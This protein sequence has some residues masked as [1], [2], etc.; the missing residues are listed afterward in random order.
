[1]KS[2]LARMEALRKGGAARLNALLER[3]ATTPV[4]ATAETPLP[5]SVPSADTLREWAGMSRPI[6][7]AARARVE[8]SGHSLALARREIWPDF[9]LGIQ[10]GQ[11]SSEGGT[12]RMASVMVGFSVP[13]FA[14]SRQYRRREEADA[15]RQM[16]DARLAEV[17][18]AI[19][20]AIGELLADLDRSRTLAGLYRTEILPQAAAAVQ[21]A[22]SAYRV[23]N[24]D[25][26]TLLD[27]QMAWN[28]YQQELHGLVAD[29]GATLARLESVA[30]REIPVQAPLL[31]EAG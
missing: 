2:E 29:Y 9:T 18:V 20:A 19:D 21:S 17:R 4:G 6:L 12:A 15:I 22:L 31:A 25:F 8:Q 27:A 16:A 5:L 30:G 28:R 23:G 7:R 11:R 1:M 3:P 14:A 10:Y 24:V 26:L 13:V